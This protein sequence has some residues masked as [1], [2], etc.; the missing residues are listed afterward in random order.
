MNRIYF[1]IGICLISGISAFERARKSRVPASAGAHADVEIVVA[2]RCSSRETTIGS[3]LIAQLATKGRAER[4][5]I[6]LF[7]DVPAVLSAVP[8]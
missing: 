1:F 2:S 3:G 7:I 4:E 6:Q 8:A 5:S